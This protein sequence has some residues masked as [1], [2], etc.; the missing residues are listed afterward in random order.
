MLIME[1]DIGGIHGQSTRNGTLQ[2]EGCHMI[3]L[4]TEK[5]FRKPAVA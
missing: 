5:H 3:K 2:W 1:K 4:S